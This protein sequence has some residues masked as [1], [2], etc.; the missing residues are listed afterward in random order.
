[1]GFDL[2]MYRNRL[3]IGKPKGFD[4]QF[5]REQLVEEDDYLIRTCRDEDFAES[6]EADSEQRPRATTVIFDWDSPAVAPWRR[7]FSPSIRW[8]FLVLLVLFASA[9]LAHRRSRR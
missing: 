1:M 8:P 2:S 9:P 5:W 3:P 7:L 6:L 4:G